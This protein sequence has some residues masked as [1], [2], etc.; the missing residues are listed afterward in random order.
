MKDQ[1]LKLPNLLSIFRILLIPLFVYEYITDHPLQSGVVLV[2]SGLTDVLDGI[3]ARRFNMITDVG[4]ILDPIADKLTQISIAFCVAIKNIDNTML[5][6]LIGICIVKEIIMGLG[7]AFLLKR[8]QRPASAKWFGKLGTVI[9]YV[10]MILVIVVDFPVWINNL[11]LSIVA[12]YMVFAL[13]RYLI[14]FFSIKDGS[15]KE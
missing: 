6:V 4:K 7:A 2:V 13:F 8:G 15:Y 5:V 3:I 9:F 10:V 12:A 1:L 11:L 14:L